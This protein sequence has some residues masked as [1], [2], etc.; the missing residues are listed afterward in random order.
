MLEMKNSVRKFYEHLEMRNWPITNIRTQE[1]ERAAQM[2][3]R[4]KQIESVDNDMFFD[5]QDF[6]SSN[7]EVANILQTESKTLILL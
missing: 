1:A 3:Q 5:A 2:F 7:K 6:Q 4:Q